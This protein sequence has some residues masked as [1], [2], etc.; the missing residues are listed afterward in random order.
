M[1]QTNNEEEKEDVETVNR[2]SISPNVAPVYFNTLGN[3][4][5]IGDDFVSNDKEGEVNMSYGVTG[6]YAINDRIKIRAGINKV[7]LGYSTQN[8]I[9]SG[10]VNASVATTSVNNFDDS[11][12]NGFSSQSRA[13][14]T[15]INISAQNT[16]ILSADNVVL[17]SAPEIIASQ[18]LSSLDQRFGFIEIPVEM[19]Y[20]LVTKKMGVNL[21]GGFSTLFLDTNDVYS[22]SNGDR[23]L[24][25][26]A[27][28]L[29]ETSFSANIGL[30][31]NYHISE[32]LKLNLEPTFKYQLNTFNNTSGDFRPYFLGVYSGISFKF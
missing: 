5:S 14:S 25:G 1:A 28:N 9:V 4:S 11:E 19:E 7:E 27:T 6:S 17:S 20:S 3:G 32:K 24:I 15:N 10:G 2:W 31:V 21:I 22:V 30:G 12:V 23:T 13:R 16:S 29:N 18:Q 26:E 8:V